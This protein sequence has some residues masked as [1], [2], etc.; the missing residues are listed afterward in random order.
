MKGNSK[1]KKALLEATRRRLSSS[2]KEASL[3]TSSSAAGDS[4]VDHLPVPLLI[5]GT[6]YDEFQNLDPEVKKQIVRYLRAVAVHHGGSLIFTSTKSETL[7]KRVYGALDGLAFDRMM[8][9]GS[10]AEEG[11]SGVGGGGGGKPTISTNPSKPVIL[12]FG[13]NSFSRIGVPSGLAEVEADF[14]ALF[15]QV[16]LEQQYVSSFGGD[17]PRTDSNF[18]EPEIDKMLEYKYMLIGG[19]GGGDA[20]K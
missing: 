20:L 7:M 8:G 12:P 4:S 11:S 6:K 1:L 16:S 17:D 2:S 13:Y 10:S 18:S 14:R 19:T 3:S 5:L 9:G 15:P